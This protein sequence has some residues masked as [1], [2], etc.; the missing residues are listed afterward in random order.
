[1]PFQKGHKLAKGGLRNPPGGRPTKAQMVVKQ[2]EEETA[3]SLIEKNASRLTRRLI[4]DAMTEKGR[5]SLHLVMN[6]VLP[7]AK[8]EFDITT[9]VYD[10][11]TLAALM[12]T[13]LGRESVEAVTKALT[14]VKPL[15][16]QTNGNGNKSS[17]S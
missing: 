17:H 15:P 11:A 7:N 6:K 8:Q 12:M 2:I 5:S 16:E 3:V 1:M 9:D 10:R 4:A 14:A 13:K